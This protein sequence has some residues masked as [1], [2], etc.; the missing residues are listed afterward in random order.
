MLIHVLTCVT[1]TTLTLSLF[2][3][4]VLSEEHTS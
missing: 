1:L 4:Y 3:G 2:A